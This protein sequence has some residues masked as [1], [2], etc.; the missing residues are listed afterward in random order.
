MVK[1]VDILRRRNVNL[2]SFLNTHT[3][4]SL[5]EYC[6]D[7]QLTVIDQKLFDQL[8]HKNVQ[9]VKSNKPIPVQPEVEQVDSISKKKRRKKEEQLPEVIHLESHQQEDTHQDL[10]NL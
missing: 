8:T 6:K 10:E 7:R 3:Y 1:L 9:S 2:V 5:C 4:E